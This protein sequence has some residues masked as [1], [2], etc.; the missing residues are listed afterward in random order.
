METIK[1]N[2]TIYG[3]IRPIFLTLCFFSVFKGIFGW[4]F[5][6]TLFEYLDEIIFLMAFIILMPKFLFKTK[7][8]PI[9]FFILLFTIYS[10][11]VSLVFGVSGN[12][13]SISLQTLI[14]IKFF[15]ILLALIEL[16]KSNFDTLNSFFLLIVGFAAFG[17][18]VHLVLGG[19]FNQLIG[20]STFA[21]PNIRY[22]GFFTHPNH[23]AYLMVLYIGYILNRNYCYGI[24]LRLKDWAKVLLGIIIIVLTDSRTALL[25]VGILLFVFYWEFVKSNYKIVLGGVLTGVLGLIYVYFYTNLIDSIVENIHQTIDINSHYIRGNMVY[26]SGMIFI[27]YFPVGTGAATFGSLLSDDTVYGLYGQANRYYFKNEIGI[28]DSNIASIVGEYGFMG[29]LIFIALFV[30]SF[31]YLKSFGSGST[32]LG[33]LFFIFI[34]YC[35]TNPMLTNNVYTILSSIVMFL[36]VSQSKLKL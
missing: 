13:L 22:V 4:L 23:L 5:K 21:R 30:Y 34:M 8:K 2:K 6:T 28:Y 1:I 14:T 10:I 17:F 12:F 15:I 19:K 32:L 20:V 35:I 18:L 36:F 29:I 27:D 16:F 25:V 11:I 3:L 26:L 7:Y 9:F 33:A 31:K 24:H